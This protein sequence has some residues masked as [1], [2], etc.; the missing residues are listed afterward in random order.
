MRNFR[1]NQTVLDSPEFSELLMELEGRTVGLV[2]V[3][4]HG[5]ERGFPGGENPTV[6]VTSASGYDTAQLKETGRFFKWLQ[7]KTT[8]LY[9]LLPN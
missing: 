9:S 3:I 7:K 4:L 6:T 2:R 8:H 1:S 5:K